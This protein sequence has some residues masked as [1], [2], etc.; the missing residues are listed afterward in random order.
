NSTGNTVAVGTKSGRVQ[1]FTL[2]GKSAWTTDLAAQGVTQ[3]AASANGAWVVV[4][5][6]TVSA[7]NSAGK[8]L[9]T[10]QFTIPLVDGKVAVDTNAVY[11]VATDGK[12]LALNLQSGE[13]TRANQLPFFAS[14]AP[15]VQNDH[16]YLTTTQGQLA[17]ISA[18]SL[19]VQELVDDYHPTVGREAEKLNWYTTPIVDDTRIMGVTNALE[20][21]NDVTLVS[22]Q[23]ITPPQNAP[24]TVTLKAEDP[25]SGELPFRQPWHMD[26]PT[27][28]GAN[29]VRS[30]N[31]AIT[32]NNDSSGTVQATD[33]T[34]GKIVWTYARNDYFRGMAAVS[35]SVLL[36]TSGNQNPYNPQPDMNGVQAFNVANG[37]PLWHNEFAETRE[38]VIDMKVVGDQAFVLTYSHLLIYNAQTG[39]RL[40]TVSLTGASAFAVQNG[41]I[42]VAMMQQ[43]NSSASWQGVAPTYATKITTYNLQGQELHT[44]KLALGKKV[45]GLVGDSGIWTAV[46]DKSL[47]AITANGQVL[48]TKDLPSALV[49]NTVVMSNHTI[50][51]SQTDGVL[52]AIDSTTGAEKRSIKLPNALAALPAY[53]N[54]KLFA[55]NTLGHLQVINA[56]TLWV[57]SETS[58]YR[59][60]SGSL[61]DLN[62]HTTPIVYESGVFGIVHP[63]NSTGSTFLNLR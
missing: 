21:S 3:L 16:L 46:Q 25:T 37:R 15:V 49:G 10:H 13:L 30:G 53:D 57:E 60:Y 4:Q 62:W 5:G 23:T 11:T 17:V 6:D 38:Q 32:V 27:T 7:L 56:A 48:W 26:T 51:A 54:G 45:T 55:V 1:S 39:A 44:T 43:T 34:S 50:Y 36:L 8:K 58:S 52:R 24:T 29:V 59:G 31:L 19:F 33:L 40:A 9:W 61:S 22:L 42:A 35:S 14:S 18:T 28:L 63:P 20:T 47:T 41:Q 12:L 2:D